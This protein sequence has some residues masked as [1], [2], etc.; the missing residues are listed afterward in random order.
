MLKRFL[1]S[2]E[3]AIG[4]VSALAWMTVFVVLW[5]ATQMEALKVIAYSFF[6][7]FGAGCAYAVLIDDHYITVK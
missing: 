2:D 4:T 3:F 7:A 6:A 1:K 5:I